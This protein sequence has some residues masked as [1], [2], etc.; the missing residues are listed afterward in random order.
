[1]IHRNRP[2]HRTPGAPDRIHRRSAAANRRPA[3][4]RP[5]RLHADDRDRDLDLRD[6]G[7]VGDGASVRRRLLRGPPRHADLP[8]DRRPIHLRRRR[9]PT[10]AGPAVRAVV[11]HGAVRDG[12]VVARRGD[13]DHGRRVLRGLALRVLRAIHLATDRATRRVLRAAP[14][15][16]A[17]RRA[18]FP[19]GASPHEPA[20]RGA[21]RSFS[22]ARAR[23]ARALPGAAHRVAASCRRPDRATR[24]DRPNRASS[25][26]PEPRV[27]APEA[28]ASSARASAVRMPSDAR[29]AQRRWLPIPGPTFPSWA[30]ST[31]RSCVVFRLCTGIKRARRRG[32]V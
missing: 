8:A 30:S 19:H 29:A 9:L 20:R 18:G 25:A 7:D 27:S 3:A 32:V 10:R 28:S 17:S 11:L 15:P 22:V 21:F 6:D 24:P 12:R 13:R 14:R 23:P 5:G 1:M 16:A 4:F 2:V 26:R 31:G